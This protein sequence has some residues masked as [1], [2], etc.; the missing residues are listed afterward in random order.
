MQDELFVQDVVGACK[1][2]R[3]LED[4]V[5]LVLSGRMAW[6]AWIGVMFGTVPTKQTFTHAFKNNADTVYSLCYSKIK[7]VNN[8][9]GSSHFA[10][11]PVSLREGSK[12][13]LPAKCLFIFGGLHGGMAE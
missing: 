1:E 13:A 3:A 11:H 7:M 5:F 8:H 6:K 9:F 12:L 4:G 2:Q 10:S